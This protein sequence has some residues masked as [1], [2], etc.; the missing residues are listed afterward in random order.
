MKKTTVIL[1]LLGFMFTAKELF[2]QGS[3]MIA[4]GGGEAAGG[5]SDAPYR[6]VVDHTVNKRI[7]VLT[8]DTGASNWIPD[9]FRSLGAKYAR[10]FIISS[11]SAADAQAV[12][13]SLVTYDGVFIKGGDQ[14]KYYE[15][16]KGT[17]TLAALQKIFDNGGVNSG[18]SAGAAIISPVAYTA[19]VASVDAATAL[20]YAYSSQIT[21]SGDFL[22][23]WPERYIYDTHFIERGRFGRLPSFMASWY[24]LKNE[25][26]TGIGVDDH[27]ALCM[28]KSGDALVF[29]TGAVTIIRNKAVISPY[30]PDSEVMRAANMEITQLLHGCRINL[31]TGLISGFARNVRPPS[32]G[33]TGYFTLYF[34][35]TDYPVEEAL[36]Y[37]VKNAGSPADHITLV[38]GSQLSRATDIR[39][40]LLAR[41]AGEVNIVQAIPGKENDPTMKSAIEKARKFLFISN[42]YEVL[43][44][45]MKSAGNG[46]LLSN[47]LKEDGMI[48]FFAGD[49]GRFAGKTVI[50]KYTGF[51][52]SSYNGTM[53]FLPGLGLLKTSALMP[54]AFISSN[55]Y[56][57]TVSGLP[58]AMVR[59]TLAF[60]F[61]ITG[62]TFAEYK[63]AGTSYRIKN[64]SGSFPLIFL[65]NKSSNSGFANQGPGALSRNIAGFDQMELKFL[66]VSDSAEVGRPVVSINE[67]RNQTDFIVYPSP[68]SDRIYIDGPVTG[69]YFAIF[70][71]TGKR[72]KS[73]V[74]NGKAEIPVTDVSPG[75]LLVTVWAEKP[76]VRF[77]CKI[78]VNRNR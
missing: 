13:D 78:P 35:G 3:V 76:A 5:W 20:M 29:G 44:P 18:T 70:D 69:G 52:T 50:N 41:G 56:E 27:T 22:R 46:T 48:S 11:R 54:N 39:T 2:S 34:S 43:M 8:Y 47:R 10:N 71:S 49:N 66:G 30:D 74:F 26:A 67:R 23:T 38:T 12:Y 6:W 68:A 14:A 37:F 40:V 63:K 36:S 16:Y 77:V 19:E 31:K 59:D 42:S 75:L 72:V 24:K 58:Y 64:I 53:E 28:E 45:F 55:T 17:K 51:G 57:N 25:P 9:Y 62:T 15:Y 7:A 1:I 60:G 32:G 73:G 65:V 4:G 21:L 33:E 61:Y